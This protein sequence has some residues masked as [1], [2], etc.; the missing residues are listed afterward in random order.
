MDVAAATVVGAVAPPV[1]LTAG[2]PAASVWPRL[3]CAAR[4]PLV[5]FHARR[6]GLPTAAASAMAREDEKE[7]SMTAEWFR[8]PSSATMKVAY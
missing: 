3:R 5:A 2:V 7:L 6:P 8:K 4:G 1:A